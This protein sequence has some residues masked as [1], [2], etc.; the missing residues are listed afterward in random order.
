MSSSPSLGGR[1]ST[2]TIRGY[3]E[4]YSRRIVG[5]C[6]S[7]TG[8]RCIADGHSA[9]MPR[10][11]ILSATFHWTRHI[12]Y[13]PR[14]KP[15]EPEVPYLLPTVRTQQ[16]LIVFL[17]TRARGR[18]HRV[19]PRGADMEN[20]K[21]QRLTE[22]S[23]GPKPTGTSRPGLQGLGTMEATS[24]TLASGA[25]WTESSVHLFYCLRLCSSLSLPP[26]AFPPA[27]TRKTLTRALS[28]TGVSPTT[29]L[30]LPSPKRACSPKT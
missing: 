6:V 10:H 30:A 25:T 26:A 20:R 17:A 16:N 27:L 11:S 21:R 28:F 19:H 13:M 2:P 8:G 4:Q 29:F 15:L 1:V 18:K 7:V 9:L 23:Q 14:P 22:L 3:I 5:P 12:A 24:H